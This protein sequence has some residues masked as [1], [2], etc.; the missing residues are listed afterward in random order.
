MVFFSGMPNEAAGPVADSY[1]SSI[2]DIRVRGL[3]GGS[4]TV[5]YFRMIGEVDAYNT[6]RLD[7]P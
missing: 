2:R 3:P 5:N 4:R 6:G 1:T 7:Q